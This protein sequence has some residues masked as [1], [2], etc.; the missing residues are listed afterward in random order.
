VSRPNRTEAKWPSSAR[1][2]ARAVGK[3]FTGG[4][5]RP[6]IFVDLRGYTAASQ[7][8]PSQQ[9]AS[10]LDALYDECADKTIGDVIMAL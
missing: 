9:M 10:T 5:A 4:F 1:Q 3:S 2:C 8:L 7:V 6:L